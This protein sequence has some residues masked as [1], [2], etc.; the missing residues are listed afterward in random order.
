MKTNVLKI[1]TFTGCFIVGYLR[2]ETVN[3]LRLCENFEDKVLREGEVVTVNI[4]GNDWHLGKTSCEVSLHS[5]NFSELLTYSFNEYYIGPN[6]RG[7][8]IT[9]KFIDSSVI[10]ETE[11]SKSSRFHPQIGRKYGGLPELQIRVTRRSEFDT[12]IRASIDVAIKGD[13]YL[14][15]HT[16][17]VWLTAGQLAGIVLG[18]ALLIAVIIIVVV[19]V[20]LRSKRRSGAG[21][22]PG[23]G[24]PHV[25]HQVVPQG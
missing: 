11:Y 19:C 5:Y 16:H 25:T 3:L 14:M 1:L 22:V 8:T 23:A 2:G 4:N 6:D 17:T 13:D 12:D 20:I 15:P 9:L 24:H 18:I 21:M 7:T 10:R